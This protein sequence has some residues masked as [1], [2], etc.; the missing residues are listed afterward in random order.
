MNV[1]TNGNV[2]KDVDNEF[3]VVAVSIIQDKDGC[4]ADVLLDVRN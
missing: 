3:A 2:L 4:V 1:G